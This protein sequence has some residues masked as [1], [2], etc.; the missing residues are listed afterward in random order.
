MDDSQKSQQALDFY[1]QQYN[2]LGVRLLQAHHELRA[3]RRDAYRQ[4]A[5]ARIIQ[6]LYLLVNREPTHRQTE[7]R[8]G[9][10]LVALLV[11]SLQID[12]AAVLK[13]TSPETLTV[14]HALGL[15]RAFQLT[16]AAPLSE[17]PSSLLTEQAPP[18]VREAL[19]AQGLRHWLWTASAGSRI[20]LLLGHRFER[21]E[22]IS[23]RF[24]EDNLAI[25]EAAL[26]LYEATKLSMTDHLT[27]LANRARL[28]HLLEENLMRSRRYATPFSVIMVDMDHFKLIN[29]QHGHQVG[30]Q[31]LIYLAKVLMSNT[32]AVDVV[33]RWGGEEF[34]VI[35]P[36][37][38][39]AQAARLAEK[40]RA[41]IAASEL[42]TVGSKTASLGVASYNAGDDQESIIG[43]GDA[44]LYKA[45]RNGRNQVSF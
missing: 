5:I 1:R 23:L 15:D 11:E 6:R 12:C 8:L 44:A 37:T 7:E 18:E 10:H 13:Q 2:E 4:R 22:G 9:E 26:C 36:N 35:A 19:R 28:N 31:V 42:P 45:K 43:R 39:L 38:D 27:E 30:D 33:G 25:A 3:A 32:R 20:V 21:V 34:L 16:L 14:E 24:E 40:L 29:D 17:Q 41:A